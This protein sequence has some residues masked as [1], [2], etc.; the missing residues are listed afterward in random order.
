[1]VSLTLCSQVASVDDPGPVE[2]VPLVDD[3]GPV[4]AVPLVDDPGPVEAVPLVD[5]PGPVEAVPLVD[6]ALLVASL[7]AS[8]RALG[9]RKMRREAK[10]KT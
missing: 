8:Y 9:R 10:L 1:V 5:D 4:E 3:P 7:A 2:A 6:F